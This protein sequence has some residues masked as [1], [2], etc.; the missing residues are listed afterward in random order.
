MTVMKP[1]FRSRVGFSAAS[2]C[3]GESM[4]GTAT[5]MFSANPTFAPTGAWAR[6]AWTARPRE[7]VD[8]RR[9][10]VLHQRDVL[11]VV[12][13]VVVADVGVLVVLDVPRGVWG[14]RVPDRQTL[15]VL[16]PRPLDRIEPV[17]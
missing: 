3:S 9:A 12:A 7:L 13:M 15:A 8:R 14:V 6:I 11:F 5:R 17:R 10:D 4:I 1:A 2:M 16:I